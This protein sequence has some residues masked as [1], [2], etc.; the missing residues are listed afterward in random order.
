MSAL[1]LRRSAWTAVAAL[2]LATTTTTAAH[3]D[4]AARARELFDA[5]AQAYGVG[6][7]AEAVKAFD[8]AYKAA[9]SPP[10][11][12]SLSQALRRQ[13]V[14]D[15]RRETLERALAGFNEYMQKMPQGGRRAD[16]AQ[17]IEALQAQLATLPA[18]GGPAA[19]VAPEKK[20][21]ATLILSSPTPNATL[22]IDGQ[23]PSPVP[24]AGDVSPGTH[25]LVVR[26]EGYVDTSRDVPFQDGNLI[27]LD[28]PLAE[29]PASLRLLTNPGTSISIDGRP[30]GI[31]PLPRPVELS[32]GRHVFTLLRNGRVPVSEE[33]DLGT[34]ET[35]NVR[36]DLAWSGQ[37]NAAVSLITVGSVTAIAGGAFGLVAFGRQSAAQ[38]LLAE[39]D[40]GTFSLKKLD[41]YERAARDRNRWRTA[42]FATGGAGV[43]LILTGVVLMIFDEPSS[44][45]VVTKALPPKPKETEKRAPVKS[46]EAASHWPRLV[47]VLEGSYTG[48]SALG[49]F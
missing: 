3:A 2:A 41:D 26:A 49:Q 18:S 11:L 12:F 48:L 34:G 1:S 14:V 5:G 10:I 7:F 39:R 13:Y 42:A 29:R 43:G 25:T 9:P 4:D 6:A 20:K 21:A 27:T 35:K 30:S 31:A 37:R 28:I 40:K 45:S 36:R 16:A 33:I 17:A 24:F 22:S 15:K 32:S 23:A 38:D 8:A 19:P 46:I 47:P 44:A